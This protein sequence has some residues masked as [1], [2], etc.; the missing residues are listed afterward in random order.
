MITSVWKNYVETIGISVNPVVHELMLPVA[1]SA[2]HRLFPQFPAKTLCFSPKGF[3]YSCE[4]QAV[5]VLYSDD[6]ALKL[7]YFIAMAGFVCALFAFGIPH[8]SAMRI[9]LGV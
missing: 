5:Y 7:P 8:L 6:H 2:K 4:M 9:Y 1:L 3:P